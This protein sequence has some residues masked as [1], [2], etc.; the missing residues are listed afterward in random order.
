[1]FTHLKAEISGETSVIAAAFKSF[2]GIKAH[3]DDA[4]A[5]SKTDG[6]KALEELSTALGSGDALGLAATVAQNTAA[7]AETIEP[8]PAV[9]A[10][11]VAA[12]TT[13]EASFVGHAPTISQGP[14]EPTV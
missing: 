3:L 2:F 13:G 9:A 5:A 7:H 12:S 6:G 10:L 11:P 14:A 4:I 8:P 1:M